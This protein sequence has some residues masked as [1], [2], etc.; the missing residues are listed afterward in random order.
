MNCHLRSCLLALV[1]S[2][3][4]AGCSPANGPAQDQTVAG[5]PAT[6]SLPVLVRPDGTY[7]AKALE[8]DTV[9]IKVIQNGV[10]NLQQAPSIEAGLKA[11]LEQMASFVQKA[12]TTGLP[13]L[14]RV[15][16]HRRLGRL[17]GRETQVH[18][19]DPGPRD[20]APGRP[21]PGVR[22]VHHLRQLRPG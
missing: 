22:H 12:C 13:P 16:P 4:A 21:R 20:R 9:V 14:Q 8:K 19:H 1:A 5:A 15:P 10:Q 6:A 2:S 18:H 7:P 17:P 3:L 11:N